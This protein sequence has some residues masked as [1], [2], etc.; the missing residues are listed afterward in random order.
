MLA[1]VHS[2]V[3]QGIDAVRCE[4]EVNIG[5]RQPELE[6][7]PPQIVGLADTAVREAMDRIRT[8]MVNSGF[9]FPQERLLV[10]LAPADLRKEGS[11]LELPIA[12]GVLHA[13][14]SIRG[15]KHKHFLVAGELALDGSV[16]PIKGALSM[17][18]L[19]VES[20]K[21]GVLLPPDNAREAAVVPGVAV[22]A[23]DS[24]STLTGF[25]NGQLDLQAEAPPEQQSEVGAGD[26]D[27]DFADVRGQE[28]A[29]RALTIAAAGRHNVL[30]LGPP[31]AGKTMLCQ[32]LPTIL[33]P[34]TRHEAL[35]TTRIYSACGLL[36]KNIS[37]MRTRPVRTP[38]HSAS[39]AALIGGGSIPRPGEVSLAHH[40][41]LFL[42]ELPEFSRR[43]LEML[44]QPLEAGT[45]TISRAHSSVCFPARCMLVAAMNPSASGKGTIQRSNGGTQDMAMEK[46][47]GRLSGPLLDRIDIH[48]EVP[49]VTYRDLT[50]KREGQSSADMRK[51]VERARK[52]Q[53]QRFG[54][55]S[56]MTNAAMRTTQLKEHCALDEPSLM[57]MKQAMEELGLSARAFDKVRRVAR[58]IA[59][60]E[61]SPAITASHISEAVQYRLLDRR[62]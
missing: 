49:A 7:R 5:G 46:Y 3:L 9:A 18:M 15:D 52:A 36:P 50:S 24:I 4:V 43:V 38:H 33:P 16:R 6:Q 8:A 59:D 44:R 35:E 10:N 25:L 41:I 61:D 39:G 42:D 31:G 32:R 58:T 62:Y 48:L 56:T 34:L 2:F 21:Q 14:K 19:A 45:V 1:K 55:H 29:K 37:L 40:G 28:L 11:A 57:L 30:L 60:M 22:Y 51:Q 13:S 20:G 53:A 17:A 27:V 54:E 47:L 12:L 23:I 26:Y